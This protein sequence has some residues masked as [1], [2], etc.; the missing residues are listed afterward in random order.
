MP[1]FQQDGNDYYYSVSIAAYTY[2]L[3]NNYFKT[4]NDAT[5]NKFLFNATWLRDNCIYTEF[6]FCSYRSFFPLKSYKLTTDWTSAM[7]QG[8][9]ISS[10]IAAHFITGDDSFAQV[11]YD[12]VS[13]YIY[14]ISAKGLSSDFND[15][16][17]Y[18]EYGSEEMPARL[19][20]GFL[21]SLSGVYDFIKAY[22]EEFSQTV[23]D[24][25]VD[26]L[27]SNIGLFD[28]KFTSRY[29]YSPLNQLASTKSGPDIYHELHIFQ[30]GWLSSI[31][32]DEEI[33]SYAHLFL[34]QDMGGIKSVY[35][36]YQESKDILKIDASHTIEPINFGADKLTDANWTWNGYWSSNQLPVTLDLTV[37]DDILEAGLLENLVL[38]SV[39]KQYFPTSIDLYEI[40]KNGQ[41]N[42]LKSNITIADMNYD[43]YEHVVG[44]FKSYTVVLPINVTI[45]HTQI[46]IIINSTESGSV[47]LRELDLHY[48]KNQLLHKILSYYPYL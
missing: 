41:E 14:P 17:W 45:N 11:A 29:D 48:P 35:R 43:E 19:L 20:N 12:A 6:G 21:F 36:L 42:L 30:L 46:R 27:K 28:F 10:L 7:A 37:N 8:Q 24:I 25:G 40:D 16:L 9:A 2:D 32:E 38:T 13:A 1:L 4:N 18:E 34:K 47:L 22:D 3:Y 31:T 5:L 26:S 44:G 39:S 23:F 33:E 15:K